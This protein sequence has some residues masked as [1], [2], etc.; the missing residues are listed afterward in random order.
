MSV[1]GFSVMD[2]HLH[3]LVRWTR[4]PDWLVRRRGRPA[5]GPALPPRDKSRQPLPVSK[6][7]VEWR[8]QDV[9]WVAT[10]RTRLQSLS[11]FMKCLKE[12]LARLANRQDQTRGAFLKGRSYCLHFPCLTN[13][14][15]TDVLGAG[16]DRCHGGAIV[17]GLV[18]GE[19]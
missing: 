17:R 7:W 9:Q 6:A 13:W 12:P 1:A 2:N 5:L 14:E 8:V 16:P 4:T 11:W 18:A 15:N 19:H 3:V 10:A